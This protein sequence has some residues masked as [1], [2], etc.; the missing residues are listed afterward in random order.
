[1]RRLIL[2]AWL[3]LLAIPAFCAAPSALF[4]MTD[5]A[6]SVRSFLAHSGKIDLLVP[7]WYSVDESGLVTGA[8]NA[9]VLKACRLCPSSRSSGKPSSTIWPAAKPHKSA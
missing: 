7:A 8:P 2:A 3:C 6:D 5:A 9:T 1:M 4:Y